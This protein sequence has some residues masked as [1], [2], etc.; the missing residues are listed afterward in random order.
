MARGSAQATGLITERA[1]AKVNVTLRVLG[2]RPDGYHELESLVTFAD[3]ADDVRLTI[4]A[5]PDVSLQ[6]DFADA[7]SGENIV[8]RALTSLAQ[9]E[10][11]LRL[12]SIAIDKAI[13][14]AAGL[15]GGSADAAA[16]LRAVK[17]A[18]PELAHHVD[19]QGIAA[20]LGADVPVCF[21]DRP[22][23]MWGIGEHVAPISGLP[24]L[25]AVLA[26]PRIAPPTD[27]TR[28]VFSR[29]GSKRIASRPSAPAELPH[30]DSA[31]DLISYLRTHENDL[32]TPARELMPVCVEV[33]QALA[34]YA[35]CQLVRMSGAGP[36]CFGLFDTEEAARSAA[37]QLSNVHP[38]WW[39]RA[40]TLG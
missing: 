27:K 8:Q 9:V 30:F 12:G 26:N 28:Q 3:V 4:G 13:P 29:L 18:N 38:G 2:R 25:N 31:D 22:A 35:G 40:T 23:L 10:P 21:G 19:W 14:V 15:G 34:A 1:R 16:V 33:E 24:R 37:R 17:R 7:V 5:S 39:V 6:G 36:T 11:H 32:A 20:R